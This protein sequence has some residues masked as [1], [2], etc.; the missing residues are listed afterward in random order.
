MNSQFPDFKKEMEKISVPTEKLDAIIKNTINENR[1]KKSK[2]KI[3]L[4]S[5]GAAVIGFGLFIGS[6]SISPTMAK[7]ASNIPIIGTFFNNAKDEGLRVAGEQGLTQIVNQTSKDNGITLTINEIFY[8]GTRL[9]LGYT[10]ETLLTIGEIERPNIEVDGKDINFSSSY[11]GD[12][13]TPQKYQGIIDV[14]PTEEL[15]EEF[16]IKLRIDAVGLIPGRWEFEF[17]VKQSNE[18]TVIRPKEVKN[19]DGAE[20][21]ISTIKIGPAGTDLNVKVVKDEENNKLDPFSLNFYVIDDNG[22][23]L[24]TVTGSGSGETENGKEKATL[25]FLYSPLKEGAK[26][27]RIIPYTI[28]ITDNGWEEVVV[29][30]NEQNLPLA[31]EQGDVGRVLITDI[32]HQEDRMDVYF[33][34]Q[35]ESII[36]NRLSRNAIWVEDATGKNLMVDDKPFAER[37]KGN[38]FKQEFATGKKE[39]LLIKTMKYPKPIMYEEFEIA[40][41]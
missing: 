4:Y 8:D 14:T 5:L 22:N 25:Q 33:D 38:S 36:D 1:N 26:K 11:S 24:D 23:V 19:I 13:I 16:D 31:L 27:V 17:P 7:I 9:T 41:P 34:V 39:G 20:V 37:I 21:E 40:I 29:P 2:K 12:F 15:P 10:Q 6:A 30:L 35:S 28:P 3:A 32:T 18:V